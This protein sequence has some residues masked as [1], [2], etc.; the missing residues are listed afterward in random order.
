MVLVKTHLIPKNYEVHQLLAG[1]EFAKDFKTNPIHRIAVQF[2]NYS[3]LIVDKIEGTSILIDAGG[4]DVDSILAFCKDRQLR[5]IISLFSH[6]H[7]DHTGGFI[8][9]G[10]S[11][12]KGK[13]NPKLPGVA[14][15]VER[16]IPVGLGAEDI[17][18][19][20]KQ[21]E[22]QKES[23][24]AIEDNLEINLGE[25]CV[26]KALKTPGHTWGSI[27]FLFGKKEDVAVGKGLL[28]TGD[29]L[30]IGTCGRSDLPESSPTALLQSLKRLSKLDED[31]IVLPGHNYAFETTS[32]ISQE[33][34]TNGAMQQAMNFDFSTLSQFR[35]DVLADVEHGHLGIEVAID[36]ESMLRRAVDTELSKQ[37][38][39]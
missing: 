26:L 35:E 19:V 20:C 1:R 13:H 2:Q 10:F 12:F 5:P 29:T 39:L 9:P 6:A 25:D 36:C 18:T 7:P 23:L 11:P 34:D 31:T 38:F 24:I 4:W 14:D 17:P 30:F 37:C 22:V 28:F 8:R 3:Y 33:R 32:S 16:T 27:C 15:Y 21:S